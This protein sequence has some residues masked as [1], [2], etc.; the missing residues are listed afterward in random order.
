MDL[1][2]RTGGGKNDI[3]GSE[4][5]ARIIFF[6]ELFRERVSLKFQ[7]RVPWVDETD[8]ADF[9]GFALW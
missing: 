4:E 1:A 3:R 8:A 7:R 5:R 2:A 6:N 9:F